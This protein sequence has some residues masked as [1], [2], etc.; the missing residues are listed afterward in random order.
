MNSLSLNQMDSVA[1]PSVPS[2][3]ATSIENTNYADAIHSEVSSSITLSDRIVAH[4]N[5][6]DTELDAKMPNFVIQEKIDK[7][8]GEL[9]QKFSAFTDFNTWLN[10]NDQ[11]N[12]Y[13]QLATF[14]VKLPVRAV[15]N[16]INLLYSII[17]GILYSVTHPLKSA[18]HAVHLLALLALELSKP[19]TYTKI[20]AGMMGTSLGHCLIAGNPLSILGLG[21]GAAMI[22]GGLSFGALKAAIESQGFVGAKLNLSTQLEQ[23]PEALLTSF[24]MGLLIGGV[25][26]AIYEKQAQAVAEAN[27][28]KANEYAK[29]IMEAIYGDDASIT[30]VQIDSSGNVIVQTIETSDDSFIKSMESTWEINSLGANLNSSIVKFSSI[31]TTITIT[32]HPG[33]MEGVDY[34]WDNLSLSE[35]FPGVFDP[36]MP[37]SKSNLV[38]NPIHTLMAGCGT[39]VYSK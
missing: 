37:L 33:I 31:E 12:W 24:F 39:S 29:E 19:E 21:I 9:E 22:V 14:L 8:A 28:E 32:P 36:L 15:R 11:G 7:I 5:K 34:P 18:N 13:H 1:S 30:D 4:L 20:G 25:R 26:K 27:M 6:W 17:K 10:S 35:G 3:P 23:L 2:N 16:I 38:L